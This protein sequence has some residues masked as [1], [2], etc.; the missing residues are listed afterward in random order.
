[1]KELNP[2]KIIKSKKDNTIYISTKSI[3]SF[4]FIHIVTDIY[5]IFVLSFFFNIFW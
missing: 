3:Q 5:H 4:Q 1:M 2:K